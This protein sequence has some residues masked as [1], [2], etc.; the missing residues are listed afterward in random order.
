MVVTEGAGMATV[1]RTMEAISGLDRGK[2]AHHRP[3][4]QGDNHEPHTG[5]GVGILVPEQLGPLAGGQSHA[6]DEHGQ[7]CGHI[8]QMGD[9]GHQGLRQG[10]LPHIEDEV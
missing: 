5:S 1:M 3:G 4:E 10:D 9:G 6:S 2:Q 7:G 8:G